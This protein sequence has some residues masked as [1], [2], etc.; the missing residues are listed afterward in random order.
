[1]Y[2]YFIHF[3]LSF[4]EIYKFYFQMKSFFQHANKHNLTLFLTKTCLK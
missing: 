3:K 1:M 4:A 2:K